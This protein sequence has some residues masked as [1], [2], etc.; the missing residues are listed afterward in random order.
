[1]YI[2]IYYVFCINLVQNGSFFGKFGV[3]CFLVNPV[4]RFGLITEGLYFQS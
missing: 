4:V 3:L 1:M 2:R